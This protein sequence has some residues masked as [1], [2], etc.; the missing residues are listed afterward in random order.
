VLHGSALIAPEPA[1]TTTANLNRRVDVKNRNVALASARAVPD[2]RPLRWS[3]FVVPFV[4]ALVLVT[5]SASAQ[6]TDE[7]KC[8]DFTEY[9][10]PCTATEQFGYCLENAIGS[11]DDCLD[12]F[13]LLGKIG[14]TIAY[15]VD[16][17]ACV[18]GLPVTAVKAALK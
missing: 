18:L 9:N 10:R 5:S 14:C 1:Q 8:S 16:Y 7:E 17:Y 4:V 15:E 12:D 6:D 11:F 13:G 3:L 2:R